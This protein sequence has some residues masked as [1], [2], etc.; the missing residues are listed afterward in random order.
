MFHKETAHTAGFNQQPPQAFICPISQEL[1][2]YPV[3][4]CNGNSYEHGSISAWFT[5]GHITDPLTNQPLESI[6]LIANLGLRSQ[7]Q[8]WIA[9]N[10]EASRHFFNPVVCPLPSVYQTQQHSPSQPPDQDFLPSA[11]PTPDQDFSAGRDDANDEKRMSRFLF[12]E[13]MLHDKDL[14]QLYMRTLDILNHATCSDDRKSAHFSALEHMLSQ[15]EVDHNAVCQYLQSVTEND[16]PTNATDSEGNLVPNKLTKLYNTVFETDRAATIKRAQKRTGESAAVGSAPSSAAARMAHIQSSAAARAQSEAAARI[17]RVQSESAARIAHEKLRIV[18]DELKQGR[19]QSLIKSCQENARYYSAREGKGLLVK[20]GWLWDTRDVLT[21]STRKAQALNLQDI[22]SAKKEIIRVQDHLVGV[23]EHIAKNVVET[24]A[25]ITHIKNG[26]LPTKN[27]I[28]EA[29]KG[30][31]R[32]TKGVGQGVGVALA[33]GVLGYEFYTNIRAWRKGEIDG[34]SCT[35]NVASSISSMGAGFAGGAAGGAGVGFLTGGPIGAFVGGVS[36]SI[37]CG[38]AASL[39]TKKAFEWMLGTD[40]ERVVVKAYKKLGLNPTASNNEVREQYMALVQEL[41]P[42]ASSKRLP[43][44]EFIEVNAAYEIIRV[45]REEP[46][47][48]KALACTVHY[49]NTLSNPCG[50]LTLATGSYTAV[51]SRTS[52]SL[53]HAEGH[54]VVAGQRAA[55]RSD[56]ANSFEFTVFIPA[57]LEVFA[58]AHSW[59]TGPMITGP[60]SFAVEITGAEEEQEQEQEQKQEQ[61]EKPKH[62]SQ[63]S[64]ERRTKRQAAIRAKVLQDSQ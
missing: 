30:V 3:I 33:V 26:I 41:H 9:V 50:G 53:Q 43:S 34:A 51:V 52:S 56:R 36:C 60:T 21:D 54:L 63:V 40:K 32:D 37:A 12:L 18:Q 14:H 31:L 11:P 39:V 47:F 6:I 2:V 23:Q 64:K 25:G 4:T 15:R 17:A 24:N 13:R 8:E 19:L 16:L 57:N 45:Q 48:R 44:K 61:E 59:I 49:G 58:S 20:K 27:G 1:M 28:I 46:S 7:I 42:H 62:R 55:F 22:V 10:P 38:L 35:S 5:E 29:K